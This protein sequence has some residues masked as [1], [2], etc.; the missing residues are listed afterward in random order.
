MGGNMDDLLMVPSE[1]FSQ[2]DIRDIKRSMKI[3]MAYRPTIV[4]VAAVSDDEKE[5]KI[6]FIPCFG[7]PVTQDVYDSVRD[8]FVLCAS[9]FY[10]VGSVPVS[11]RI[12]LDESEWS[13]EI[14]LP[15]S[16][17]KRYLT[18]EQKQGFANWKAKFDKDSHRFITAQML[19]VY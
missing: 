5:N 16:V 19:G 17:I 13:S 4:Y 3:E 8:G 9:E 1:T 11:Y 10:K 7:S 15:M 12:E 6:L 18:E 14:P 2:K